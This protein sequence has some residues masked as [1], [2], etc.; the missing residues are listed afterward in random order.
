MD[1]VINTDLISSPLNVAVIWALVLL[2]MT[3]CLVIYSHLPDQ[4]D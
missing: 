2:A 1:K 4:E 3:A